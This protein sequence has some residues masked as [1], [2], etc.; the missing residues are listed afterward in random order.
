MYTKTLILYSPL[1]YVAIKR[2]T[3]SGLISHLTKN[4]LRMDNPSLQ[5][6]ILSS[7][8]FEWNAWHCISLGFFIFLMF[9]VENT[10]KNGCQIMHINLFIKNDNRIFH[11]V[12]VQLLFESRYFTL[13]QS[14]TFIEV[15][16]NTRKFFFY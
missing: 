6:L 15:K 8:Y 11:L 9:K 10:L 2:R 12:T 13:I 5:T 14:K 1:M 4:R 3:L 7:T 16:Q